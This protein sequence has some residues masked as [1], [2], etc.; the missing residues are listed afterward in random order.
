ME[1]MII[2]RADFNRLDPRGR[3]RLG[4]LAM[5]EQTPFADIAHRSSSILFV[6]G[7]DAVQGHLVWLPDA[8]WLGDVDWS[9]QQLI[10]SWPPVTVGAH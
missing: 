3:L 8:G 4:G 7:E 10:E 5:H 2:I 1:A 9:T 6:D